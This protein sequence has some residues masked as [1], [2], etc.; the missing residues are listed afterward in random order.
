MA[1]IKKLFAKLNISIKIHF[2]FLHVFCHFCCPFAY[3]FLTHT[4]IFFSFVL[5]L[6][7]SKATSTEEFLCIHTECLIYIFLGL[8]MGRGREF[9]EVFSS[10]LGW[11]M[12]GLHSDFATVL[13][14]MC[15]VPAVTRHKK[16][17]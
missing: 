12:G 1:T 4:C 9:R 6:K 15:P 5:F 11:G 17:I 16:G 14:F 2:C 10:V 13:P 8:G 3:L 7:Y